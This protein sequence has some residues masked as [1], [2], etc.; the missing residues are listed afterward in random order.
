MEKETELIFKDILNYSEEFEHCKDCVYCDR[1][2]DTLIYSCS[3]LGTDNTMPVQP[4][5][6]CDKWDDGEEH[7]EGAD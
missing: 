5:G 1:V 2:E 6:S 3:L 4:H 7:D